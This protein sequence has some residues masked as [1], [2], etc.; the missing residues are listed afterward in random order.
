MNEQVKATWLQ[1]LR[2]PSVTKCSGALS[3]GPRCYCAEEHSPKAFIRCFPEE[4]YAWDQTSNSLIHIDAKRGSTKAWKL[5]VPKAMREHAGVQVGD[6]FVKTAALE[7]WLAQNG[8]RKAR[9]CRIL[10]TN[11]PLCGF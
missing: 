11:T 5:D 10:C 3:R 9:A 2:D 8:I 7:A 1:I 4:G 6:L